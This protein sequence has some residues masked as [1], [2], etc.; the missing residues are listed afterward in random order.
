V[1]ITSGRVTRIFRGSSDFTYTVIEGGAW[2]EDNFIDDDNDFA[3][4]DVFND[5][6]LKLI[7]T[8]KQ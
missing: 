4:G 5:N 6:N 1:I 8:I 7:T 2:N 3:N